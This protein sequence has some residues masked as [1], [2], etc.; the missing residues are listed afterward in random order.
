MPNIDLSQEELD[1]LFDIL[2]KVKGSYHRSRQRYVHD[3]LYSKLYEL[4]TF[5]SERSADIIGRV[6]V[7]DD[8]GGSKGMEPTK[9]EIERMGDYWS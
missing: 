5:D 1:V 6:E 8:I 9:E 4:C 7:V 2:H 3:I